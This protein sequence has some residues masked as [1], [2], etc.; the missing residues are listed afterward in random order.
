MNKP[1]LVVNGDLIM[2][3]NFRNIY[4]YHIKSKND[5]TLMVKKIS[6]SIPYAVVNISYKNNVTNLVEKPKMEYFYNTG[7]Y[8]FNFQSIHNLIQKKKLICQILS[9]Y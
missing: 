5:L 8:L 2:N 4:D 3:I 9:N 1:L 6:S 7:V